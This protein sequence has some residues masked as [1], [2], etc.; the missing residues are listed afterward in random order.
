M[1]KNK[2]KSNL[3]WIYIL[4][5]DNGNYY[6][7]YTRDLTRRFQQH[8]EG[9]VKYTRS[10]RPICIAQSWQLLDEIGVAL[11]IERFVKKQD[12]KT[13]ELFIQHPDRLK[14]MVSKKLQIYTELDSRTPLSK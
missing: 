2:K 6:T 4:K 5:C 1:K 10:F 3:F 9:K 12:K 14:E 7:G 11:K 13:K 8:L